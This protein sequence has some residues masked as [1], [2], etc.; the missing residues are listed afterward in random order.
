MNLQGA[1]VLKLEGNTLPPITALSNITATSAD[2]NFGNVNTACSIAP[3]TGQCVRITT[4]LQGAHFVA[5]IDATVTVSGSAAATSKLGVS[6]PAAAGTNAR[7]YN[8]C[9]SNG[10]CNADPSSIWNNQAF[11]IDIPLAPTA[12]LNELGAAIASGATVEHQLVVQV[13]DTIAAGGV[14]PVV[15]SYVAT[16][17]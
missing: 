4:G 1:I 11:G 17:N 10:S 7:R 3:T 5:T 15:V 14:S 2:V 6:A 13:L 8:V 12:A 9:G 16:S